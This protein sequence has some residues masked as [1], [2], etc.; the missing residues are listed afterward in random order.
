VEAVYQARKVFVV[1]TRSAELTP[2]IQTG[3]AARDKR[4]GA[5]QERGVGT[6]RPGS[7]EGSAL[8]VEAIRENL[9]VA[10]VS[11]KLIV[12]AAA[13]VK[14]SVGRRFRAV[15]APRCV[16]GLSGISTYLA[17]HPGNTPWPW[18]EDVGHAACVSCAGALRRELP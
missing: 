13:P 7:V 9:D 4:K 2:D 18:F 15:A 8:S 14:W 1:G 3:A 5:I 11:G 10:I 17:G 6:G 16:I 12:I